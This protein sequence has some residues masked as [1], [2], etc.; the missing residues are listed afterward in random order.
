MSKILIETYRGFDIKFDTEYEKFQCI[1]TEENTK[2]SS[3]FAAVKKFVD[4]YKKEN[5]NFNPFFVEQT[6]TTRYMYSKKDTLK[7][8]GIRKDGR[9]VAE[10][11][12]GEKVQI[13]DYDLKNYMLVKPE[14]K[15]ILKQLE[16]LKAKEEKQTRENNEARAKIIS[17]L[18]II[19][20]EEY[21]DSLK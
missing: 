21:K 11:E 7:I 3:S 12:N 20:L 10:K 19:T 9:F 8:I 16:E 17:T 2:E 5:Q 15:K 13:S 4:D 1:V 18:N 14:N 6:A